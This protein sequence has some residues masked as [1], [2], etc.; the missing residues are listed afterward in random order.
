[1]RTVLVGAFVF[2]AGLFLAPPSSAVM[3]A[4]PGARA[5]PGITLVDGGCGPAFYRAPNGYCYRKPAYYAPGYAPGYAPAPSPYYQNYQRA[6]APGFHLT[7]YG[8]RP[9]W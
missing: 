8:C 6:C 5:E 4:D 7:P 9:N 2:A 3:L 1:M